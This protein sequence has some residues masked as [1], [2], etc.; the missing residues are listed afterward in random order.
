MGNTIKPDELC[1]CG[2]NS[3]IRSQ[4]QAANLHEHILSA[5]DE[6]IIKQYQLMDG[7]LTP[8]KE[9]PK[10]KTNIYALEITPDSKY[11]FIAG[12][13]GFLQQYALAE[14]QL[15]KD[16]G[17]TCSTSHGLV[18]E[19]CHIKA[20]AIS[21]DS[22]YLFTSD[23]RG[24]LKQYDVAKKELTSNLGQIHTG[25]IFSL[26][27]TPDSEFLF[28]STEYGILR[29]YKIGKLFFMLI[30]HRR[31]SRGDMYVQRSWESFSGINLF[32]QDFK[33]VKF[34]VREQ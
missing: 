6:G 15:L 4:S 18:E 1:C 11:F 14:Q 33:E 32:N 21:P 31:K 13:N 17:E 26:V 27:V 7:K 20:M 22:K 19:K 10:V 16:Y 34:T 24:H 28:T 2:S 29:Q 12:V 5:G 23:D 9:Y 3:N 8:L 30:N 25:G